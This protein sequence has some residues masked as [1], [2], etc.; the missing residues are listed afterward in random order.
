MVSARAAHL[1]AITL[2]ASSCA[3]GE[4]IIEAHVDAVAD[5]CDSA[6]RVDLPASGEA[7]VYTDA[8]GARHNLDLCGPGEVDLVLHVPNVSGRLSY[9]CSHVAYYFK[10]TCG[11]DPRPMACHSEPVSEPTS[12]PG[13]VAGGSRI[14]IKTPDTFEMEDL[15]IV[16]CQPEDDLAMIVLSLD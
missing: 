11:Q 13:R 10:G 4:P 15:Y 14:R 3:A 6:V 12:A 5:V 2:C 16:R 1:L 9:W 8:I 7:H